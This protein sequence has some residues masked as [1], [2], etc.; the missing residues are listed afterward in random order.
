[1]LTTWAEIEAKRRNLGLSRE[2]MCRR[3]GVNQSTITKGLRRSTKPSSS[4][5]RQLQSVLEAAAASNVEPQEAS[6]ASGQ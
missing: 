5:R 4:I 3:S 2:E 6:H 1:M